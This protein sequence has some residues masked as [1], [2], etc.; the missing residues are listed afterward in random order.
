MTKL[1]WESI[2]ALAQRKATILTKTK[3]PFQIVAASD[4]TI[5]VRVRSHQ[6][7]TISRSNL[8]LAVERIRA[9][10]TL[11]GPKDYRDKI[12]DDRPAYAWAI[13]RELGFLK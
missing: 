12:A 3:I 13:L 4:E 1:N 7:Y 10:V 8:E 9:G 2:R 11:N 6:E 5:I